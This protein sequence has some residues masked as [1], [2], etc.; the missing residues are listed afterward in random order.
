MDQAGEWRRLCGLLDDDETVWQAVETALQ[1]GG[2]P[3]EAL[4]DGLD[5][6][7]ALAYL[8]VGDTGMELTD[9]LAQ[10]PRVF[11]LQPDL[12]AATDTDDLEEAMR[13][14]DR[15]LVPGRL[16]LLRLIE[17]DDP[18]SWPVVVVPVDSAEAIRGLA[19]ALGR[20]VRPST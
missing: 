1:E 17:D 10:L 4:L 5:D 11:E 12:G 2:D 8:Q 13:T 15:A 18:E 20:Q 6:A 7:G 9:A 19:D 16:Q 14:A 3:W